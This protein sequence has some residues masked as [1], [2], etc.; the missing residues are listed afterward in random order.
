MDEE[1][2]DVIELTNDP[3]VN[4]DEENKETLIEE[5][6]RTSDAG[7]EEKMIPQ[8]E[9]NKL[10]GS[11]RQETREKTRQELKEELK[12]QILKE[13]YD[14]LQVKDETEMEGIVEKG[15]KYDE[16]NS[17]LEAKSSELISLQEENTLLKSN[18]KPEKWEDAKLILKGKGLEITPENIEKEMETH[19]EW[20]KPSEEAPQPKSH[21]KI[22]GESVD[23]KPK[24]NDADEIMKK[25]FNI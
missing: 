17:N 12:N 7:E 9:V 3:V 11:V 23:N 13:F 25:Y 15:H 8:S 6:T 19:P 21:I 20:S 1:K 16:L 24:G 18:I 4:N 5:D 2:K 22:F 14:K 10:V